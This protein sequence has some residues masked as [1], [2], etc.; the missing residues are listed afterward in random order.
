MFMQP[1]FSAT[2]DNRPALPK[3]PA[4]FLVALLLS[5]GL[6]ILVV[7][8]L[9]LAPPTGAQTP[10]RETVLH[11]APV[12][13]F[14]PVPQTVPSSPPK[15]VTTVDRTTI[16]ENPAT[17]PQVQTESIE[18][19]SVDRPAEVRSSSSLSPSEL[20]TQL[21]QQTQADFEAEVQAQ[22]GATSVW[23]DNG[24]YNLPGSVQADNVFN[25][26]MH[27]ITGLS[28]IQ[29]VENYRDLN[30]F[31]QKVIKLKNGTRLCGERQPPPNFEPFATSIFTWKKC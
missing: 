16:M 28:G 15:P 18:S 23:S 19:S 29:E 4:W 11:R 5:L 10:A 13:P 12:T 14:V 24:G 27:G 31:D 22:S 2:M 8:Y 20:R 7:S 17:A 6:H 1:S 21:R 9:Q 25:N 30:G 26:R 3:L